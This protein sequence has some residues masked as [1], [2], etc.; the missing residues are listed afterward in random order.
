MRPAISDLPKAHLHLHFTG[1][2]RHGTLLELAERGRQS[3]TVALGQLEQRPV[4]HRT[5]E[6]EVQ[7]CLGQVGDRGPHHGQSWH[8]PRRLPDGLC[9]AGSTR[10]G[11]TPYTGTNLWMTR[12]SACLRAGRPPRD[13]PRALAQL[14]E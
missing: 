9:G 4:T 6:V 12:C 2:M 13:T 8:V 5:G 7:V 3:H 14:A 1:S 10:W 11:L